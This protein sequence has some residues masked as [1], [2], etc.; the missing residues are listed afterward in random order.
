M[1]RIAAILI[2]LAFGIGAYAQDM[3]DFARNTRRLEVGINIGQA[4][5]FSPYADFGMGLNL[6]AAGFY[7]DCLVASPQHKYN[8]TVSNTKW[9]DT[10]AFC[11]NAGY[12]IPIFN[13]LRIMPIVGYAQT[14][15]GIT[16]GSSLDW[17]YGENST[18]FYHHYTVT[19]GSRIH[20][21]NYGGGISIQ[22]CRWFSINA[23][24]TRCALYG[25]IA[26][27][28]LAFSE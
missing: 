23:V 14:N 6:V 21:F 20:Y 8:H 19:P 10:E 27:N 4:G 11:I 15:E 5:S 24:A 2:L 13:W 9:N 18:T 22:P 17:S 7:A 12:Q 25:G 3:F 28:L 26:F 16:D 1:K